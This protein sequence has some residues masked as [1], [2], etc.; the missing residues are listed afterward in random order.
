MK[1]RTVGGYT[2]LIG[3]YA[4]HNL[5][6]LEERMEF[7]DNLETHLNA[8][9]ACA[10]LIVGDFNARIGDRKAGESDVFG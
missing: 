3:V 2:A 1:I 6:P 10:K 5:R 9:K 7:Y 8:V 4:P